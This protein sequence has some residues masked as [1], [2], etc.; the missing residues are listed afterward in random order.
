MLEQIPPTPRR[1]GVRFGFETLLRSPVLGGVL[2]SK[3]IMGGDF[4]SSVGVRH[5]IF[6][7]VGI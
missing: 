1:W 3:F 4:A 5:F 6:F 7:S 2:H